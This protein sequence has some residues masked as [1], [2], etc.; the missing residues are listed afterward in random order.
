MT[1]EDV[2]LA[3]LY[4]KL[5]KLVHTQPSMRTYLVALSDILRERRVRP[6]QL[7][8]VGLQMAARNMI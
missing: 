4:W 6:V 7:N 8:E 1:A 3:A 2:D 5:Q